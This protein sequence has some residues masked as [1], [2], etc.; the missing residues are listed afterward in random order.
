MNK[1]C[2]NF[3]AKFLYAVDSVS[4]IRNLTVKFDTKPWFGTDVLMLF[5]T[6]IS[7]IKNST[8]QAR[9]L[10]KTILNMQNFHLK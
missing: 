3:V 1:A 4:P 10:I 2:K 8:N 9:Q 7:T 5:E 6:V